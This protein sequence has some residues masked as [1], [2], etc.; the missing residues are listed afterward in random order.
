MEQMGQ[1]PVANSVHLPQSIS[2]HLSVLQ[3]RTVKASLNRVD[4]MCFICHTAQTSH[5]CSQCGSQ[6]SLIT[7]QSNKE[8]AFR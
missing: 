4:A 3:I 6:A 2:L 5:E 7:L 1:N 8:K